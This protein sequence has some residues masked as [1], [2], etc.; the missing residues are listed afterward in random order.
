[1]SLFLTACADYTPTPKSMVQ[2][3]TQSQTIALH[4]ETL[5][6]P[7][8]QPS[9]LQITIGQIPLERLQSATI[10][11]NHP[12]LIRSPAYAKLYDALWQSGVPY[13]QILTEV[14][15]DP[16]QKAEL[17]FE[18]T[19]VYQE[20]GDPKHCPDWR[21]SPIINYDNSA[22]SNHGCATTKNLGAMVK[23]RSDIL[24]GRGI[25]NAQMESSLRAIDLYYQ[26]EMTPTHMEGG[27]TEN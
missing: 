10:L 6:I 21:H 12:A 25:H 20:I 27:A 8:H 26:G 7:P 24:E 4:P 22:M 15:H 23:H 1:M 17:I 9:Q 18:V 16:K 14:R 19:L 11:A 13:S 2:I 5:Q 3:E